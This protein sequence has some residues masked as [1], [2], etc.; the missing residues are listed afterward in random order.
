MVIG[1][2]VNFQ[3]KRRWDIT[4]SR[5]VRAMVV[6]KRLSFELSDEKKLEFIGFTHR[7]RVIRKRALNFQMKRSWNLVSRTYVSG[8][9]RSFEL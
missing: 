6:R 3:T 8:Q 2:A 1:G 4:V 7:V 5:T 9:Q